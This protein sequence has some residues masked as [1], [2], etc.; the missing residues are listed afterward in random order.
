MASGVEPDEVVENE[1]GDTV[2]K[3]GAGLGSSFWW[4]W[5]SSSFSNLAD[6]MAKIALPLIAVGVTDSPVLI[7]GLGVALTSPWLLFAL[8]AGAVVDRV[9]RRR[10]MFVANTFRATLLL[11]LALLFLLDLGSIWALYVVAFGIGTAETLYDT[12]AQS[13]LP[14]VVGRQLLSRAN[15]R[16]HAAELTANQFIGPP[17][18]GLLVAAGA[19]V[20]LAAPAALWVVA[21][22]LLLL[23]C[24][25]FRVNHNSG[26]TLR[27]DIAEGL[28][29]LWRNQI[30]R[31]FAIM[32]GVFN[33]ASSATFTIL[34]LHA[35]G[36]GSS[37]QLSEPGYALLLTSV[38]AGMLVGSLAA[39]WVEKRL[40]RFLSLAVALTGSTLIYAVLIFSA[41]PLL[42]GAGFF[43]GGVAIALWNVIAVSL[44][45]RITPDHLLGRINSSNRLLAWGT[46]P[47]GAA[48]G[49]VIAEYFGFQAVFVTMGLLTVAVLAGLGSITNKKI[50]NAEREAAMPVQQQGA[51]SGHVVLLGD[52]IFDNQAYVDGGPDVAQQLRQE[53]PGDWSCTLLAVDGDRIADVVRQL[54]LLPP[55]TTHLVVSVGGNDALGFAPLLEEDAGTVTDALL[56]LGKAQDRFA[57]D[58]DAMIGAIAVKGLPTAVGTIYD[59]PPSAPGQR[60]IRTALALFN[61][62]ITRAAFQRGVS[63]IDLRLICNED[64]DY[65]NPIE[66]SVH[67]GQKIARAIAAFVLSNGKEQRSIVVAAEPQD[68]TAL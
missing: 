46:L 47:L 63:V 58:Y 52:S 40:G 15:A 48:A 16:L 64:R 37:L 6:G 51:S 61:D 56:I 8:L 14:Q 4:L 65:A 23:V 55:D 11:I 62:S 24:G 25:S 13:I 34:V 45:Q 20:S 18:G 49:G 38:A 54:R 53:L 5:G 22:G 19:A 50:E 29:F 67:G 9:D 36:P 30:L 39:A 31:T 21:V 43:A 26:S 7:A 32:V 33:F 1:A 2:V 57:A 35:V 41:N 42:I 17:L 60:I 59:T 3:P 68:Q 10:A 44:R 28:R 27:S 66:P 12:S